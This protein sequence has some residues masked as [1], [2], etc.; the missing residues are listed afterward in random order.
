[1]KILDSDCFTEITMKIQKKLNLMKI[2]IK[3]KEKS[4]NGNLNNIEND[5]E[6]QFYK[7]QKY[8]Y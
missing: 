1:M 7:K 3:M 6:I 4:H 8:I 5:K 2:Q